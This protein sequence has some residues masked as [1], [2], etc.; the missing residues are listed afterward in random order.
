M[1]ALL[2]ESSSAGVLCGRRQRAHGPLGVPAPPRSTSR[3]VRLQRAGCAAMDST[4]ALIIAP[5]SIAIRS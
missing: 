2:A 1:T 4:L 5:T 3:M